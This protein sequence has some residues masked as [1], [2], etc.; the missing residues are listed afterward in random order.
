MDFVHFFAVQVNPEM[1]SFD[2]VLVIP[3]CTYYANP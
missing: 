1:E 3:K 2:L